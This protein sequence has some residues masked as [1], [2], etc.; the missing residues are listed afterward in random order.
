MATPAYE[1]SAA[2]QFTAL[3]GAHADS[4]AHFQASQRHHDAHGA[5]GGGGKQEADVVGA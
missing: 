4:R 2:E 5:D 3:P 1:D